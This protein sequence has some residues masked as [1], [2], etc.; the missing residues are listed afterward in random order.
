[1]LL[2]FNN[3]PETA[4]ENFK[5]GAL[6]ANMRIFDDGHKKIMKIRLES[7]AS[8]GKHTH[9]DNSEI[10]YCLSGNGEV[11]TE[12]EKELLSPGNV[13]YCPKGGTH[14]LRNAGEE[15]LVVFA[16]VG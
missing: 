10:F 7:G 9:T 3:I 2:D 13:H 1:M 5:G 16:I 6:A 11:I 8:I 14:M 12:G 15:D 4:H